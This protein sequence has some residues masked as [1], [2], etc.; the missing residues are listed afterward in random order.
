MILAQSKALFINPQTFFVDMIC[1]TKKGKKD[2]LIERLTEAILD[3]DRQAKAKFT[4][5]YY[6]IKK[7]ATVHLVLKLSGC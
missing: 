3:T 7:E 2:E 5:S 6:N 4:L 1:K